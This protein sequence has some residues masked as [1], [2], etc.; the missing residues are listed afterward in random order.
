E[1]LE[2]GREH[3][4]RH[5]EANLVVALSGAAVGDAPRTH[6]AG[7]PDHLV[8][9]QRP[10]EARH[11]RVLPLVQ[12]VC[13]D[14]SRQELVGE[15][16]DRIDH[17]DLRGSGPFAALANES[18]VLLLADV[19]R[20]GEH[21]V[22]ALGEPPDGHRG[23][24]TSR[25]RKGHALHASSI[26]D[27]RVRST[28]RGETPSLGTTRIVLSPAIVPATSESSARSRASARALAAPAG[29][30]ITSNWFAA[31][32]DRANSRSAWPSRAAGAAGASSPG[33]T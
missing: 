7:D 4:E 9:D 20:H 13:L 8:G 25:V 23:V 1:N 6:L 22:P 33:R 11:H 2:V 26:A 14:R 21:L 24:Q 31:M 10:G 19:H 30:R 15:P 28:V 5:L 3:A 16:V 29:V 27:R 12:A 17:A 18:E 32:I